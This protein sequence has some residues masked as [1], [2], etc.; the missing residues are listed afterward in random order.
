MNKVCCRKDP[1]ILSSP[2]LTNVVSFDKLLIPPPLPPPPTGRCLCPHLSDD[3]MKLH[4]CLSEVSGIGQSS[5]SLLSHTCP[6]TLPGDWKVQ[7]NSSHSTLVVSTDTTG[8]GWRMDEPI[9]TGCLYMPSG[10]LQVGN[11]I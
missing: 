3:S 9:L 11:Q 4:A 6:V 8:W 1:Y 7:Q 10:A 5:F 2:L